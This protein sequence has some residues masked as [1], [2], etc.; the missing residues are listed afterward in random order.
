MLKRGRT[1]EAPPGSWRPAVE[2]GNGMMGRDEGRRMPQGDQSANG[3]AQDEL[4][5]FNALVL[6]HARAVHGIAT[7]LVG[8]L[9]AEDAAQEA[10]V[11]AWDHWPH[12]RDRA[13]FRAWLLRITINVCRDWQRGHFG[14]RARL[15]EP[16]PEGD[17]LTRALSASGPGGNDHVAAMDLRRAI[18]QLNEDLRTIIVLRYYVGLDASEIG[19]IVEAPAATVHTRLRRALA[20]LHEA[21]LSSGNYP[22]PQTNHQADR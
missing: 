3:N 18:N 7:A 10:I 4:R 16:F 19:A 11:R 13:A 14:T 22:T 21:L 6:A 17:A 20:L 5:E 8:A 9:D 1:T 2:E 12:L 15:T